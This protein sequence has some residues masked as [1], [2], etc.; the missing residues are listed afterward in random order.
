MKKFFC[1]LLIFVPFLCQAQ[2]VEAKIDVFSGDTIVKAKKVTLV[3]VRNHNLF[4]EIQVLNKDYYLSC[5][6]EQKYRS[7]TQ[8][9]GESKLYFAFE[10]GTV[11]GITL[12]AV[13]DSGRRNLGR[14]FYTV[15]LYTID[16]DVLECLASKRVVKLKV[17]TNERDIE[18]PVSSSRAKSLSKQAKAILNFS[19]NDKKLKRL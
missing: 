12:H 18:Y 7:Y 6:F 5:Q 11:E 10:D 9:E 14:T 16:L 17:D 13:E 8:K 3:H 2:I 4:V 1:L 19:F 15:A